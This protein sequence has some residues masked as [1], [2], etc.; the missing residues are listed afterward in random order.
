MDMG[1]GWEGNNGILLVMVMIFY[2]FFDIVI[3]KA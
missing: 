2:F 1:C 3:E